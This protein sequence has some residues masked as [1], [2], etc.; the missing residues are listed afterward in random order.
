MKSE[1]APKGVFE[2]IERVCVLDESWVDLMLK[3]VLYAIFILVSRLKHKNLHKYT[4]LIQII[5]YKQYT[6]S[7]HK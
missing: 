6:I 2:T 3:N 4:Y 7:L 5:D 1:K